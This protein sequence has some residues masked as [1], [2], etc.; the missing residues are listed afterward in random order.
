MK[1]STKVLLGMIGFF[2]ILFCIMYPSSIPGKEPIVYETLE[3]FKEETNIPFYKMYSLYDY[4]IEDK[5]VIL[6]EEKDC[7]IKCQKRSK[8]SYRIEEDNH[9]YSVFYGKKT[10]DKETIYKNIGDSEI[11]IRKYEGY[12]CIVYSSKNVTYDIY[13]DIEDKRE[14]YSKIE[15]YIID[16]EKLNNPL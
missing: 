8:D 9:S 16:V 12:L 10:L 3:D 15:Q 7:I 13:L 1:N 2:L 14:Y 4:L 5:K 11:S 6:G